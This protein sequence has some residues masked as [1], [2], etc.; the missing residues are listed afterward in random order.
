MKKFTTK[1]QNIKNW[2]NFNLFKSKRKLARV[3]QKFSNYPVIIKLA[4]VFH[5]KNQTS[6]SQADTLNYF[7]LAWVCVNPDK[8]I[9]FY[10]IKYS[11]LKSHWALANSAAAILLWYSYFILIFYL[12][13]ITSN[14]DCCSIITKISNIEFKNQYK[15]NLTGKLKSLNVKTKFF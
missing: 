10:S 12:N 7:K 15:T 4:W 13:H 1:S 2:I 5:K 9:T 14:I 11:Y 3:F 6:L 8:V